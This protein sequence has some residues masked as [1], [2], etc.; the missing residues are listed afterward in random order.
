MSVHS[1]CAELEIRVQIGA[2]NADVKQIDKELELKGGNR[3]VS[4]GYC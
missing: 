1:Y 3:V 4:A 2:W